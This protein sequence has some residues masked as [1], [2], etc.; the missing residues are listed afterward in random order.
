MAWFTCF[1]PFPVSIIYQHTRILLRHFK[2]PKHFPF[3]TYHFY[4]LMYLWWVF[5]ACLQKFSQI[6]KLSGLSCVA[7]V[8]IQFIWQT[9]DSCSLYS[10][11]CSYL[12]GLLSITISRD[13]ENYTG[14]W[15]GE[16][17][18]VHGTGR[19]C[20]CNGCS[21][22]CLLYWKINIVMVNMV[23]AVWRWMDGWIN[24]LVNR[25]N[26]SINKVKKQ[27]PIHKF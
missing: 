11:L 14:V 10:F 18:W 13:K 7:Y 6:V 15:W 3:S 16:F 12:F 1:S 20:I 4:N 26:K 2:N 25:V 8:T 23:T 24:T 27:I 21:N 5:F 9:Q 19:Y 22:F 17:N